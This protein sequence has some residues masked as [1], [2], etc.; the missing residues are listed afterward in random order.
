VAAS[1]LSLTAPRF[2]VVVPTRG[3][4]GLVLRLVELLRDQEFHDFEVVV[5]VDGEDDETVGA[6]RA[7]KLPFALTVLEQPH[8]GAA[9]ARN[10]GA[11]VARGEILFFLDD[12]MAPDAALLAEHDRSYRAG[13]EMVLGHLPLDPASPKTATAA[14]IGGWAERRRARLAASDGAVP[15]TELISGQMS[16]YRG[17]FDRLGGFDL[18]F[19]RGGLVPGADRDFGYRA[20]RAGLKIVF[21]PDAISHQFYAVD[22]EDFTRRT[23]NGARGDR[24]LAARYPEIADEL[25]RPRFNSLLAKIVLGPLVRLPFSW[26]APLRALAVR[27]FSRPAPGRISKRLFFAVQTMER[28]RGA[29][30]EIGALRTPIAYVLA[31]HSISD[32]SG[33]A[34]LAR[35]GIPPEAFA[36]QLDHLSG[37]GWSFVDLDRFLDAVAGG[38]PLPPRSILLT[39]DDAY[40]DLLTAACPILRERRLPSV[41]FAVA[42]HLGGTNV[43]RRSDALELP[44]LDAAGLREVAE[45]G[46]V[47]GSH[48]A[49]HRPLDS[50]SA[51]EL[52]GEL[53]GSAETLESLGLP[54]P[55]TFSYPHGAWSPAIAAAVQAAGYRAAFTVGGGGI[56]RL[57]DR[58]ALPRIEVLA[59]ETE[60]TLERKLRRHV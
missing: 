14:S 20:R 37:L 28:Q 11:A 7:L 36:R 18:A 40:V 44:L 43:W 27:G 6:L 4:G 42:N 56:R 34:R 13:A 17:A 22:A 31:Y 52:P 46:I 41:A 59:D 26:S 35:Y 53:A 47:I 9:A 51:E 49:T 48:G 19:T 45:S 12:D 16:I 1:D 33:D 29:R 15:V 32:L 55:T 8:A 23:R 5:V 39:F 54:R 25:W 3:R 30:E 10:A 2:S 21:N 50:I 58:Y 60:T 24:I 38:A 57:A